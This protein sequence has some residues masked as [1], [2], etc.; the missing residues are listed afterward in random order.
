M[1]FSS[2]NKGKDAGG[3]WKE[4]DYTGFRRPSRKDRRSGKAG[5][6][7]ASAGHRCEGEVRM[8]LARR[9]FAGAVA[10]AVGFCAPA[11]ADLITIDLAASTDTMTFSKNN[12]GEIQLV[13]DGGDG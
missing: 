3:T 7:L 12:K 8:Q 1:R 5:A 6:A 4:K 2:L 9:I 13:F 10:V 11:I